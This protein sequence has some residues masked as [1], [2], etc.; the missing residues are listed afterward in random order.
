MFGNVYFLKI[1]SILF[2]LRTIGQGD[3]VRWLS[4]LF[5]VVAVGLSLALVHA[6]EPSK[7]TGTGTGADFD[8]KQLEHDRIMEAAER[9]LPDDPI[10][11]T[12]TQCPRSSG[13]LHD[14]YSEGDYWWPNS[15]NPDGPYVQRDGM[16]NP[17]NFVDHRNAMIRFSIHVGTLT[18]AYRLTGEQKYA[19]QANKHFQAWFIDESTRMNPNLQYA[20][21][22][23]GISKGR[24][25]GIIDT[26]QLIEVARSA[27]VLEHAGALQGE[28]LSG[29]KKWFADYV[30]WLTTSPN[31]LE[32]MKAANNHGTCWVMQV[33]AFSDFIGN[34]QQL[35]ACRKRFREVLLPEQMA[36]D[37]SFPREL[38]RTKPYGYSLFNADAMATI[39]QI[40]STPQDNLW[41]YTTAEGRNMRS[42]T[43]FLFPYLQDKSKWPYQHDI[44]CWDFW[45]VRSPLLLFSGLAYHEPKYLELWRMLEANPNNAE[46]IRNLPIRHPLLWVD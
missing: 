6:E 33:A 3:L 18:S 2:R 30:Q 25:I 19:N 35:A 36:A 37:G 45:P 10:T 20:Q 7:A 16:T 4:P 11:V 5:T 26:V 13:G 38:R 43:E 23:K 29:T 34:E 17:D 44:M 24:G 8:I 31:G 12:A 39:C 14:F 22:I 27:Q 1:V 40:L 42:A 28:C 46:V 15:E 21:A 32:E 9:L 41:T